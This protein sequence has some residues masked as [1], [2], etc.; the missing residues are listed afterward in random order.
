MY[1]DELDTSHGELPRSYFNQR[2]GAELA[3]FRRTSQP[4]SCIA[5]VLS[6]EEPWTSIEWLTKPVMELLTTSCRPCDTVCDMGDGTFVIL[7]PATRTSKAAHLVTRIRAQLHGVLTPLGVPWGFG[8][9]RPLV[10]SDAHPVDRA[11]EAAKANVGGGYT[12]HT[13]SISNDRRFREDHA[14]RQSA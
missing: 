11:I 9:S 7:A 12:G 6:P 1:V 2:L 5:L 3:L 8:I 13:Y 10:L 14:L 4:L